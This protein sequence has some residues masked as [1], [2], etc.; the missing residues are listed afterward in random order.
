[1]SEAGTN[2]E[3]SLSREFKATQCEQT[4]NVVY[5]MAAVIVFLLII[6]VYQYLAYKYNSSISTT[7]K[8]G[9]QEPSTIEKHP[10]LNLNPQI[11]NGINQKFIGSWHT[12]DTRNGALVSFQ[13]DNT[14][15]LQV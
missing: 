11:V 8:Y 1:M 2:V 15:A 4:N 5:Y 6:I 9:V 14:G 13:F 12:S 3:T 7:S 10:N